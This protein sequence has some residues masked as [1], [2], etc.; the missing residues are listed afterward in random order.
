MTAGGN[1]SKGSGASD[2]RTCFATAAFLFAART[3]CARCCSAAR[4]AALACAAETDTWRAVRAV[5]AELA[6][7]FLLT[8]ARSRD[9]IR[10][11]VA[12]GAI[13]AAVVCCATRGNM[14]Q[15]ARQAANAIATTIRKLEVPT[16]PTLVAGY[17]NGVGPENS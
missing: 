8:A 10:A 9:T 14:P 17:Y 11:V 3:T 4:E 5:A 13:A 6:A 7:M 1:T 16:R 12:T 15:P 2:F